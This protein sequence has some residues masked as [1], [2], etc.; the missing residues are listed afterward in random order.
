MHWAAKGSG[1]LYPGA[2]TPDPCSTSAAEELV[3][4]KCK[5]A[6][7]IQSLASA[8]RETLMLLKGSGPGNAVGPAKGCMLLSESEEAPASCS[9]N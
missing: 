7:M 3:S 8:V 1:W 5:R 2:G 9:A 6:S 4:W